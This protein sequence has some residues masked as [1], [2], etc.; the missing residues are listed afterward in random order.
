MLKP[1]AVA[2]GPFA[3]SYWANHITHMAAK[4]KE[5]SWILLER[6]GSVKM[7]PLISKVTKETEQIYVYI[8]GIEWRRKAELKRAF[9]NWKT[10]RM[11]RKKRWKRDDEDWRSGRSQERMENPRS[12][13]A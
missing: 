4:R 1:F 6:S 11:Q 8:H 10:R 7:S 12:N 3:S 13:R 5:K 9:V 2:D